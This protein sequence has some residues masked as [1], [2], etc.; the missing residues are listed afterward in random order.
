MHLIY[1][2][3]GANAALRLP[4][5]APEDRGGGKEKLDDPDGPSFAPAA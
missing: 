3:A 5:V 4:T 1:D 2:A